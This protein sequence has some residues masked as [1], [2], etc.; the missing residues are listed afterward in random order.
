MIPPHCTLGELLLGGGTFI[1]AVGGLILAGFNTITG[2][3]TNRAVNRIE[4]NGHGTPTPAPEGNA[5]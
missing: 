1:G 3:R 2:R 4:K 5:A